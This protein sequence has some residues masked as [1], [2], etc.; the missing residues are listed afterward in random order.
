MCLLKMPS[1][2]LTA[3]MVINNG[4]HIHRHHMKSPNK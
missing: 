3:Y 4:D 2:Y 1:N